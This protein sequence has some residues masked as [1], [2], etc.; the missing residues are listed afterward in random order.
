M[1]ILGSLYF[2][3]SYIVPFVFVLSVV[4]FFHEMGHFLVGRWCG[5]K[6]DAFSLGFGPEIFAFTDKRGTR[7]RLAA[8]PLGGFVKFHGDANA[9][10]MS[11]AE[12]I[13]A[14]PAEERAVSFFSQKV[15]KRAAI[16]A[17]GPMANFLLAIVIFTC[18]FFGYGREVLAPRI[19][20]VR[21]GEAGEVAGFQAGD[22]IVSINGEAIGTWNEMQRVVQMS[23]GVPLSFVVRRGTQEVTLNATPRQRD[24]DTPFGKH[25]VGLLGVTA[26]SEVTDWRIERY[27]LVQSARIA[28]QETWFIIDRT[29]SYIGGVFSGRETAEQISGPIRIAEISGEVAKV[30]IGALLNLAAILSVSVGLINLFPVPLLDGGHLLYYLVEALRGRPMSE[31]AQELGFKVGIALVGALMIFATFNDVLHL[32]RG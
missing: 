6:V 27:S 3:A 9:A 28:T 24:V 15:W 8:L 25:R 17:A 16:V 11:D 22:L 5:V 7:W 10:S 4:V 19:E 23:G 12:Q 13:A 26:S 1:N 14:M 29:V 2:V 32:S 18:I 30:G 31:R 21:A 20:S